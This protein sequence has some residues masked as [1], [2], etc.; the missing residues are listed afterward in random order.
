M[1]T[2]RDQTSHTIRPPSPPH[3]PLLLPSSL[4]L[5]S[6][7]LPCK[8][9]SPHL[10]SCL[11]PSLLRPRLSQAAASPPRSHTIACNSVATAPHSSAS[12][13]ITSVPISSAAS[14]LALPAIVSTAP[15]AAT[16]VVSS[17]AVSV[18]AVHAPSTVASV[19]PASFAILISTTA[20]S[21]L[22]ACLSLARRITSIARCHHC[23]NVS[24]RRPSSSVICRRRLSSV[25][26]PLGFI[27]NLSR[28][29]A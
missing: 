21:A 18:V 15:P 1:K 11:S 2:T 9:S 24:C 26:R 25:R 29:H 19:L 14:V 16:S 10:Q 6:P 23:P 4:L 3:R 12:V 27:L 8:P 20:V 13:A 7:S 5:L 22:S 17:P 28:C